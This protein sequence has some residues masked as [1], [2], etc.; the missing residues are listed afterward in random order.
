MADLDQSMT[1]SLSLFFT[2]AQQSANA[3]IALWP[4]LK[5]REKRKEK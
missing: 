2:V 4:L 3:Q 1:F 5:E